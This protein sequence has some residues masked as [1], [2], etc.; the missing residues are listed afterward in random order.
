MLDVM[1]LLMKFSSSL[2]VAVII[3]LSFI[4]FCKTSFSNWLLNNTNAIFS[5]IFYVWAQAKL[6]QNVY[7]GVKHRLHGSIHFKVN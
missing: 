2:M 4:S 6:A 5:H 1:K 3:H 7:S